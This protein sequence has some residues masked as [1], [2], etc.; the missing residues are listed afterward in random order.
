MHAATKRSATSVI[1]HEPTS[2]WMP[3][4]T[5]RNL[6][7]PARLEGSNV[8]Y[9]VRED[10]KLDAS[11]LSLHDQNMLF[12]YSNEWKDKG[13]AEIAVVEDMFERKV[14]GSAG[15]VSK[16]KVIRDMHH[17]EFSD[18]CMLTP[19]WLARATKITGPRNPLD[20]ALE[21]HEET[22]AFLKAA[23]APRS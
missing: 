9:S 16:V 10:H 14:F 6:F 22:L 15:G 3:D 2:L 8:D 1:A 4:A 5:H 21:A 23:V 18:S 12:L 7:D 11:K 19:L 20:T 17:N 13:W